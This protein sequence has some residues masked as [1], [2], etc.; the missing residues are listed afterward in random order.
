MSDASETPCE[1]RILNKAELITVGVTNDN[2]ESLAKVM[3][4]LSEAPKG[5]TPICK[6]IK[7]ITLRVKEM[8]EELISNETIALIIILSDGIS[9]DGDVIESLKALEGTPIQII[10]RVSSDESAIIE[11][12]NEISTRVDIDILILDDLECEG[13][14]IEENNSWMTY[15]EPLHRA[16]EFGAILPKMNNIDYC[17]LSLEDIKTVVQML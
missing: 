3:T 13:T 9:T 12:W 7:E 8:E 10:I 11:Y 17:Q 14:Q 5:D 1:V 15:G 16:R 4:L 6:Q 2:G